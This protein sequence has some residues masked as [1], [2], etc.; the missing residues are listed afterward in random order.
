MGSA[1]SFRVEVVRIFRMDRVSIH[2]Y[3]HMECL[4]QQ[5]IEVIVSTNRRSI[6]YPMAD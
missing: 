1:L 5:N 6:V 3:H 4:E 2:E